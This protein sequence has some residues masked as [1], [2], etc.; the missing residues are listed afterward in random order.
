MEGKVHHRLRRVP[1]APLA[2]DG[3]GH[4]HGLLQGPEL[5]E[6]E[7]RGPD[8]LVALGASAAV[9]PG[10]VEVDLEDVLEE[11]LVVGG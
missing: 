3:D 2:A 10:L 9:G 5:R 11:A 1:E 4:I 8:V 6:V 7:R